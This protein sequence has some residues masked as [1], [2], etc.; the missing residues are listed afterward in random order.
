MKQPSQVDVLHNRWTLC[1]QTIQCDSF[2]K[3]AQEK[4]IRSSTL[5]ESSPLT[6][7]SVSMNSVFRCS[8]DKV[9]S[10]RFCTCSM[11]LIPTWEIQW[12]YSRH[13][14]IRYLVAYIADC[15]FVNPWLRTSMIAWNNSQ[16]SVVVIFVKRFGWSR[17]SWVMKADVSTSECQFLLFTARWSFCNWERSS[18]K[19][20]TVGS[21]LNR[22]NYMVGWEIDSRSRVTTLTLTFRF[23]E[24][25]KWSNEA[26]LCRS[27]FNEHVVP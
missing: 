4:I 16:T 11:T 7:A 25:L 9:V 6:W 10:L 1:I 27:A 21:Y 17:F 14:Q 26:K 12:K 15:C 13:F 5:S 20:E 19:V 3:L 22:D 24:V 23:K 2:V 18:M 8:M